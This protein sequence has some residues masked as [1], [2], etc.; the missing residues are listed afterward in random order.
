M[1]EIYGEKKPTG[2]KLKSGRTLAVDGVFVAY[3]SVPQSELIKN[4]VQ[5]DERGYVVAGE[6]GITYAATKMVTMIEASSRDCMWREMSVPRHC[7]RW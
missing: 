1:T 2:I 7:V 6:D 3:G 4:L 5:L